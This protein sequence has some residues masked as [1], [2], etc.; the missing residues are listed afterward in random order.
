MYHK[1]EF[2]NMRLFLLRHGDAGF[3]LGVTKDIERKLTEKGQGQAR[4]VNIWLENQLSASAIRV[5]C[6]GAKRTRQTC[7]LAIDNLSV[8]EVTYH[9]EIYYATYKELLAFVNQISTDVEDVLLIGHNNA[10]S[11]FASYI[12]DKEVLFPTGGIIAIVFP[13]IDKWEEV[14]CGTGSEEQRYF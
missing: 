4:S 6:S 2:Q 7:K 1:S 3:E 12:L 8:D 13:M 10:I 9:D 5:Y 11:D 14:G